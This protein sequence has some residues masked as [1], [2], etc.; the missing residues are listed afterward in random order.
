MGDMVDYIVEGPCGEQDQPS[1]I[2][3]LIS[4]KNIRP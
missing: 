4:G 3:D 2:V 1:T